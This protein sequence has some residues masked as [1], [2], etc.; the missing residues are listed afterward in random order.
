MI[1]HQKTYRWALAL[2]II[3]ITALYPQNLRAQSDDFGYEL[4]I[5]SEIKLM[6]GLKLSLEAG[7]RT[8]DDAEKIDRYTVGAGLSYRLYQT[9]DKKLNVKA[10]AGFDYMWTQKL[11][12]QEVKYEDLYNDDDEWYGTRAKGYNITDEYWRN[13][14]RV[15]AGLSA[16]YSPNKRWSFSLK[17]TFQV[18]H[19]NAVDDISRTKVRIDYD[20][21][22]DPTQYYNTQ[23]DVKDIDKLAHTSSADVTSRESA[24]RTVLRSRLGASY[25]IKGLPIDLFAAVDYGCGLNYS[26]NKWKFSVGYDYKINKTNTLT[27]QYRYNT[28]DDDDEANGHLVGLSYKIEF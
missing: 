9:S 2:G 20:E 25:D 21:I 18:N 1:K 8:Q 3:V 5:E 14:S 23:L 17:E 28:E 4:G 10:N 24:T 13:R 22:D 19:Y 27:L 7:M 16:S 12:E 26:T 6:S 11:T 15:N